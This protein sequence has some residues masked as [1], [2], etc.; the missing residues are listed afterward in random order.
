MNRLVE[1]AAGRARQRGP[2]ERCRRQHP[3]RAGEHGGLVGQDVPEEV[4]GCDDV[5]VARPSDEMHR[6]RV[7]Q[8]VLVRDVGVLAR[9]LV[10]HF[11]PQPGCREDVR[12]VHR[13]EVAPTLPSEREGGPDETRHLLFRVD[14]GID[15]RTALGRRAAL[16]RAPEVDAASQLS[17]H[18][19]IDALED[20]PAERRSGKELGDGPDRSQVGVEAEPL[21]EPEQRLLRPDPGGRVVP[22]GAADRPEEHRIGGTGAGELGDRER[23]T[24]RV[25]RGAADRPGR[26]G[27]RKPVARCDGL[28]RGDR[29]GRHLGP[30]A[31]TGED[32]D[33]GLG[34]PLSRPGRL[35]VRYRRPATPAAAL[36]SSP[37]A[38]RRRR[39]PPRRSPARHRREAAGGTPSP[40]DGA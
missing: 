6:H 2:R 19:E 40:C 15:R 31:V 27:E 22:P 30:D 24:R 29:L 14:H 28:Q 16:A 39:G 4:L 3:H 33:G 38:A 12:L 23:L 26:E 7:D 11:T 35:P 8:H 37:S 13:S 36:R 34:H 20:L 1:P 9:H 10:R 18:D 32:G 17:H 21:A 5:E 25:D